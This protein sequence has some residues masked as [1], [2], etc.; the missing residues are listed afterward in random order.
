VADQLQA[1]PAVS[2][3]AGRLSPKLGVTVDAGHGTD[4]VAQ[5]SGG[6]H[7][8]DARRA[9]ARESAVS[10]LPA[11][12]TVEV[13]AR[14]DGRRV[15]A[16]ASLWRT[17]TES[18]LV[19]VGDEG[20]TEPIGR[21]RR[22]GVDLS[23]EADLRPWLALDSDL[24]L[25]RGR[26]VD[27]PAGADRV[28][29]APSRTASAGVTVRDA[30]PWS[31]GLRVRHIGTRPAD[32]RGEV[33]ARGHL[34]TRVAASYRRGR[35]EFSAAIDNL[36]DVAWNEAQFATTSRLRDERAPVTELHFTPG[37]PRQVELGIRL[38]W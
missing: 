11:A 36:F 34:L 28:P 4:L 27:E 10:P 6:L 32:E 21:A 2:R 20:T 29:L 8:S 5:A 15:R 30:G 37:A 13:G 12:R 38:T 16:S 9:V 25:A 3:W 26:L 19:Y 33:L 7:S 22:V 31:A 35:L 23:F 14:H 1:L 24:S 18:E 17:T